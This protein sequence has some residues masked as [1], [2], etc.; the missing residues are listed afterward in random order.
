MART[1]ASTI[2]WIFFAIF[3]LDKNP[4]TRFDIARAADAL[5]HS[6]PLECELDLAL[7]FLIKHELVQKRGD[8]FSITESG[9]LLLEQADGSATDVY[10]AMKALEYLIE[11]L[12]A[13]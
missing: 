7:T 5:D 13:V 8:S 2:A 11:S 6:V 3:F 9:K 1:D 10:E 4:V 12:S